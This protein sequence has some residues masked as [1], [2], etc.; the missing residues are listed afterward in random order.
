MIIDKVITKYSNETKVFTISLYFLFTTTVAIN[1]LL[2]MKNAGAQIAM[3]FSLDEGLAP[4]AIEKS[5][6]PGSHFEGTS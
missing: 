5:Q 1:E 6:N 4:M 2:C 3:N